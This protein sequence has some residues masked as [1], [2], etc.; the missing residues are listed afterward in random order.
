VG[1]DDLAEVLQDLKTGQ[2]QVKTVLLHELQT[3]VLEDLERSEI[4]LQL[5]ETQKKQTRMLE[6]MQLLLENIAEHGVQR[7]R[8]QVNSNE[9][10]IHQSTLS[11]KIQNDAI[12]A[13]T[14]AVE[15]YTEYEDICPHIMSA[16]EEH[17]DKYWECTVGR[18]YAAWVMANS[19]QFLKF[20]IGD[21][22]FRIFRVLP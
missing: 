14:E 1:G 17:H 9:L 2:Q 19:G 22:T 3:K 10:Q 5:Q 21:L 16:M 11:Q 8:P 15:Q 13:A 7:P 12:N 18:D 4:V 20:S 6:R